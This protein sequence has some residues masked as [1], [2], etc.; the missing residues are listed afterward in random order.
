MRVTFKNDD[1]NI[2]LNPEEVAYCDTLSTESLK[3]YS[4]QCLNEAYDGYLFLTKNALK[5]FTDDEGHTFT[6]VD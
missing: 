3:E 1:I 2:E 5:S 4:W 6:I